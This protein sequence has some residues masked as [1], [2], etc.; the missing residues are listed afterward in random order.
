ML[1]SADAG[2]KMQYSMAC[3]ETILRQIAIH[4]SCIDDKLINIINLFYIYHIL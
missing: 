2:L 4:S 1:G 3:I